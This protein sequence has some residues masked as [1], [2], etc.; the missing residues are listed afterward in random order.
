[1][2]TTKQNPTILTEPNSILHQKSQKVKDFGDDLKRFV[3][4][5][6]DTLFLNKGIGL[7]APQVGKPIRL[8][9]IEYNPQR[10]RDTSGASG[11]R[12]FQAAEQ[13]IPLTILINPKIVSCS[14]EKEIA[15]EGCLSLPDLAYPV[16]RAKEVRVFAQNLEGEK[17]KIR[18]KDL[19]ARVLQH[20]IDHLNGILITDKIYHRKPKKVLAH[21]PKNKL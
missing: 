20:E 7:A 14:R 13:P 9:V 3:Q 19:F 11:E 12:Q 1:M 6:T 16:M 5:L 21:Q 17:I 18:A 8:A 15:E 10:F 4:M 2:I